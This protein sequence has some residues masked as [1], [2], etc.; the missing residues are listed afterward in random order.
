MPQDEWGLSMEI[1][2][3]MSRMGKKGG[4]KGGKTAASNMTPAQRQER[5]RKAAAASAKVRS[6]KAKLKRVSSTTQAPPRTRKMD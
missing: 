1:R 2:Q 6:R 5:A 3:Y 4:A